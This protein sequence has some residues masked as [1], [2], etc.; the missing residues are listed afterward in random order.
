MF[1]CFNLGLIAFSRHWS[2]AARAQNA[3][4]DY[5]KTRPAD[6]RREGRLSSRTFRDPSGACRPW[7]PTLRRRREA[8]RRQLELVP[9]QSSNRMQFSS[10]ADR[11]H[12]R[13]DER[14]SRPAAK[15]F[16][17]SSHPTTRRSQ[18]SHAEAAKLKEWKDVK[19]KKGCMIRARGKQQIRHSESLINMLS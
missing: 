6:R 16:T 1:R 15:W 18:H 7:N 12:D 3:L 14:Q 4:D 5:Q 13:Y 17:L 8:S 11:S 9:V 19:G 10:R 2:F